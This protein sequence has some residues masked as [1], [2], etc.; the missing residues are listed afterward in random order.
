MKSNKKNR[1]LTKKLLDLG[2]FS[3]KVY[4]LLCTNPTTKYVIEKTGKDKKYVGVY[5]NRLQKKGLIKK[6]DRGLFSLTKT[7]GTSPSLTNF[8][9]PLLK[10]DTYF[11]LHNLELCLKVNK[12]NFTKI[13][14]TIYKDKK[15][16]NVHP[17]GNAGNYFELGV[18]GLITKSNIF[19]FF[20]TNFEIK[21][22]SLKELAL[23]LYDHINKTLSKWETKFNLILTKE[24][25]INFDIRNIHVA[26][27]ND[28]VTRELDSRN[29]N[30]LVI[31]DD[32]DGKRRF[33]IDMSKG[34]PEIE[35]VHPEKA[36]NDSEEIRHM[37]K[38]VYNGEYKTL[39]DSFP[40]LMDLLKVIMQSQIN[41]GTI[42]EGLSKFFESQTELLKIEILKQKQSFNIVPESNEPMDYVG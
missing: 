13:K 32:E 34:F 6:I 14:N 39:T 31:N 41:Q 42:N 27:I 4:A 19:V 7:Q 12:S 11:R 21:A 22:L 29:I 40:E 3:K 26:I 1:S 5:L 18:T 17:F 8:S 28:G 38:S 35:A 10:K 9:K 37:I 2:G 23:S 15:Y 24:G 20:P 16:F 36:I 30:H 25:R 33:V